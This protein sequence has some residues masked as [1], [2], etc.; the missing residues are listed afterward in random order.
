MD[1]RSGVLSREAEVEPWRSG[2]VLYG[3]AR[4]SSGTLRDTIKAAILARN[5]QD[6][7]WCRCVRLSATRLLRY[8]ALKSL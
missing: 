2:N 7:E 5:Q 1:L 3:S 6:S 8:D 4:R